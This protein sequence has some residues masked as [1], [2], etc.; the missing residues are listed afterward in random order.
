M[1]AYKW[2]PPHLAHVH[3]RY[4]TDSERELFGNTAQRAQDPVLP[5]AG[6]SGVAL[7]CPPG[8][9]TK[10]IT[11]FLSYQFGVTR[12]SSC[13]WSFSHLKFQDYNIATLK[14]EGRRS[15]TLPGGSRR[16][17]TGGYLPIEDY[18]MIG[19]MHTCALV[20]IDGSIDHMCW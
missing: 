3:S 12:L 14:M 13:P 8:P 17:Q 16:G 11:S 18:G 10:S 7:S 1:K 19:N 15:S 4:S 2:P 5:F 20:G 6:E 9:P